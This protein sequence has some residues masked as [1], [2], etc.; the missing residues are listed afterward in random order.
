MAKKSEIEEVKISEGT[1][2]VKVAGTE[3]PIAQVS[4]A[5]PKEV[6][7]RTS[8]EIDCYV[9]GKHYSFAKGKETSVPSDVAS[10]LVF[11]NKAFRL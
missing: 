7:I 11:S 8:E 5:T 9:G 2:E 10:I 4:S 1:P 3:A 6:K